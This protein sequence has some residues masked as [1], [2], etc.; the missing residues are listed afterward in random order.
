MVGVAL[1]AQRVTEAAHMISL[2]IFV[3]VG[4]LAGCLHFKLLSWNVYALVGQPR[5]LLT[6][7]VSLGRAVITIGAFGFAVLNGGATALIVALAG[8][9]LC[10]T[11]LTRCPQL[12]L[13]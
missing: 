9:L 8:F 13:R 4:V 6:V 1:D 3:L 10:R 2:S 11:I 7:S 5:T 12:V